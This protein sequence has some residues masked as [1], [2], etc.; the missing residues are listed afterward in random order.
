MVSVIVFDKSDAASRFMS[1]SIEGL[2][3]ITTDA[4]SGGKALCSASSIGIVI[5]AFSVEA[6][7][8]KF[9]ECGGG[10]NRGKED[11]LE[12]HYGFCHIVSAKVNKG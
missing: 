1:L 6:S 12:L 2:G 7:S 11:G 9:A 10:K 8:A 4:K 5:F 3:A